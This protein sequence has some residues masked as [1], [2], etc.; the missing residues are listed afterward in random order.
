MENESEGKAI[1]ESHSQRHEISTFYAPGV[2][3]SSKPAAPPIYRVAGG[4]RRPQGH[5]DTDVQLRAASSSPELLGLI[6]ESLARFDIGNVV[7][8][9][10][11]AAKLDDGKD[12]ATLTPSP[13]WVAL[14]GRLVACAEELEPRGMSM[15]AYA[16]AKMMCGDDPLLTGL[17]RAGT[18]RVTAFGATDVAKS[19]WAFAKLRYVQEPLAESFW[20]A[21]AKEAERT[22]SGGRFVDVSMTAWA[23]AMADVRNPKLF[24]EVAAVTR[25]EC[26]TLP[27]RSLAGIAWAMARARHR[28]HGLFAAISRQA[29]ATVVEFGPHDAAAICWAF[30][31]VR[32]AESTLFEALAARLTESGAIRRLSPPLAAELAWAFAAAR[33]NHASLFAELEEISSAKVAELET[34]DVAGFA[35]AFATVGRRNVKMWTALL[36]YAER[37]ATRFRAPELRLLA[38]AFQ[39]AGGDR[40]QELASRLA[41]LLPSS[42]LKQD[43]PAADVFVAGGLGLSNA[44]VPAA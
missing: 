25:A 34:E 40:G 33:V 10:T 17:A 6:S 38:W 8:A 7:V 37:F 30:S 29:L 26:E 4:G 42:G 15:C 23:F 35:W 19:C 22:L 36:G 11:C 41:A 24:A 32:E 14:R 2:F 44:I 5:I 13:A 9:F 3:P 27:P 21:V 12:M 43:L 20:G 18:R 16:A 28:D 31:A 39:E 1:D